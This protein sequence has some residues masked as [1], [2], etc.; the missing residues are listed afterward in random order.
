[1]FLYNLLYNA[2]LDQVKLRFFT[3]RHGFNALVIIA[4]LVAILSSFKKRFNFEHMKVSDVVQSYAYIFENIIDALGG[5]LVI[6]EAIYSLVLFSFAT[7]L[8]F[9]LYGILRLVLMLSSKS[10]VCFTNA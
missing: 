10:T 1:M 7:L 3:A 9:L 8:F 6:V 2:L 4:A 5:Q